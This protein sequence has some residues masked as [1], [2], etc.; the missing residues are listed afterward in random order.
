MFGHG[1]KPKR[2][3]TRAEGVVASSGPRQAR[4]RLLRGGRVSTVGS[5]DKASLTRARCAAQP[6]ERA[7]AEIPREPTNALCDRMMLGKVHAHT[8][9]SQLWTGSEKPRRVSAAARPTCPRPGERRSALARG[10]KREGRQPPPPGPRR[11][12]Y[13][14]GAHTECVDLHEHRKGRSARERM[15]R[16]LN[17][18]CPHDV[19]KAE[20]KRQTAPQPEAWASP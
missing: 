19:G 16:V 15:Q 4:K 6:T 14:P 12:G 9:R 20:W 5:I 8:A 10:R 1:R 18:S 3:Q 2:S 17:A 7:R 13:R 11:T